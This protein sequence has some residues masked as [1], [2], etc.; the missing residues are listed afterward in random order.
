MNMNIP[1]AERS[2]P[3]SHQAPTNYNIAVVGMA[4]RF[5]GAKNVETFWQNLRNGVESIKSFTD[6]ELLQAGVPPVLLRDPNFVKAYPALDGMEL[7]DAGFFGLSPRDA[8]I[9]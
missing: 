2:L 4:G 1:E 8:S 9:M 6:E 5:P 3:A 7:F